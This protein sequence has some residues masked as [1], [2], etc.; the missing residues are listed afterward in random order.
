MKVVSFKRLASKSILTLVYRNY[1]EF[2]NLAGFASDV[3]IRHFRTSF[4]NDMG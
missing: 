1:S 3:L 2:F 4:S